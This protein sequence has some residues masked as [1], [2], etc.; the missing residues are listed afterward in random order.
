MHD[1]G[2]IR[3]SFVWNFECLGWNVT[4]DD[5]T[6]TQCYYKKEFHFHD[7]Q[8]LFFIPFRFNWI[9]SSGKYKWQRGSFAALVQPALQQM[10]HV[11]ASDGW[12]VWGQHYVLEQGWRARRS[13]SKNFKNNWS[14]RKISEFNENIDFSDDDSS[15][16]LEPGGDQ[17]RRL[18]IGII[19]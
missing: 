11:Q 9:A 16:V 12:K 5:F 7:T 6:L 2:K 13:T 4:P 10:S 3:T 8:W 17:L 18:Q 19:T 1:K 15:I 14:I